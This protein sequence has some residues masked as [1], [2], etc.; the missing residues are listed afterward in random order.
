MS[1]DK[2][3]E[4]GKQRQQDYKDK[5]GEGDLQDKDKNDAVDLSHAEALQRKYTPLLVEAILNNDA[6]A[7]M[8]VLKK[9]DAQID[10]HYPGWEDDESMF[11]LIP[12]LTVIPIH[13]GLTSLQ[14]AATISNSDEVQQV[15]IDTGGADIYDLAAAFAP[16]DAAPIP[17]D[18]APVEAIGI[19]SSLY[20][21]SPFIDKG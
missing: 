20:L 16:H 10:K 3:K 15:L 21:F 8:D 19:G 7:V 1:K 17:H 9:Y 14:L 4:E 2:S 12:N 18:E 5:G 11:A 6:N 13:N